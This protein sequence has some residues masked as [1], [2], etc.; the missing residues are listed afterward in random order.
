MFGASRL[1]TWRKVVLPGSVP[2]VLAGMRLAVVTA[3]IALLVG[4]IGGSARGLGAVLN[5]A[6]SKL[7]GRGRVRGDRD[8]DDAVRDL[9]LGRRAASSGG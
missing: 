7:R 4:E 9:R 5:I 2:F 1:D 8:R 6:A 3:F